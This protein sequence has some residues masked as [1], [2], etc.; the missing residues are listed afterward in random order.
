MEFENVTTNY[1][2]WVDDL[3][4]GAEERNDL[5][6]AVRENDKS[7]G[8][9]LNRTDDG[10]FITAYNGNTLHL[11]EDQ[12]TAFFEYLEA[13]YVEDGGLDAAAAFEKAMRKDD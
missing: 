4:L 11:K 2:E 1:E 6:I 5:A 8:Y 7:Y 13:P 10:L 3:E 9:D 12:E